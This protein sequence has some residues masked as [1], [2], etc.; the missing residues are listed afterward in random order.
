VPASLRRLAHWPLTFDRQAGTHRPRTG[1]SR[2]VWSRCLSEA[3]IFPVYSV[4]LLARML[5]SQAVVWLHA[6]RD[7]ARKIV[8]FIA[9][10]HD[11]EQPFIVEHRVRSLAECR[12]CNALFECCDELLRVAIYQTF[13]IRGS[14]QHQRSTP[15]L[16]DG[17]PMACQPA[18]GRLQVWQVMT[19]RRMKPRPRNG[20]AAPYKAALASPRQAI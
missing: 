13:P 8:W 10:H 9:R 16:A 1:L 20:C 17:R 11:L 3:T 18:V 6:G 19:H 7:D 4:E 15:Y 2:G 5:P 12:G 14:Y